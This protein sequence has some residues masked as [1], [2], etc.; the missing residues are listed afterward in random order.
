MSSVG[1]AGREK[2]CTAA[3]TRPRRSA[4]AAGGVTHCK[5]TLVAELFL[6]GVARLGHAVGEHQQ[7]VAVV[8]LQRLFV[9]PRVAEGADDWPT[10]RQPLQVAATQQDRR[11]VAG[12][13]IDEPSV[14]RQ[15]CIHERREA[16]A[17]CA[18]GQAAVDPLQ[19]RGRPVAGRRL[20]RKHAL[21]HGREQRCR[22]PLAGHVA[23]HE[24][25]VARRQLD[26]F[27]EV[28]ADG[29][30]RQRVADRFVKRADARAARGQLPLH[31]GGGAQF[32]V[33]ARLLE[34]FQHV[35]AVVDPLVVDD[36]AVFHGE[37]HDQ[38]VGDGAA[39][40]WETEPAVS[41]RR[42]DLA[43]H[44]HAV[45][46]DEEVHVPDREI[47]ERVEQRRPRGRDRVTAAHFA[48]D[49]ADGNGVGRVAI[50]NACGVAAAGRSQQLL[51]ERQRLRAPGG[52]VCHTVPE[53][54]RE[55]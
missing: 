55:A 15:H 42:V 45:A 51:D 21:D 43:E 5:E 29:A 7:R 36:Q 2:S 24:R 49:R 50:E 16:R 8:E 17:Q 38:P 13:C 48:E 40:G 46:I 32:L 19:R 33:Q 25:A 11:I 6:A 18:R 9:E 22:G 39:G 52:L 47:R 12:V 4:G 53:L 54:S 35:R 30:A 26:R 27:E 37:Q 14:R 44:R 28:A 23:H 41:I 3:N 20:D 10:G 1:S 34:A 31:F